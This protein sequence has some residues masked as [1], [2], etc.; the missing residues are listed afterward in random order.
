MNLTGLYYRMEDPILVLPVT[1]CLAVFH[2]MD[3]VCPGAEYERNFSDNGYSFSGPAKRP[4][5]IL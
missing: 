4:M 2:N 1:S 3:T 5:R